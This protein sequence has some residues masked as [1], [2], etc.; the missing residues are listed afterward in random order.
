[1]TVYESLALGIPVISSDIYSIREV[2]ANRLGIYIYNKESSVETCIRDHLD[3]ILSLDR[4]A[5]INNFDS[6]E[7]VNNSRFLTDLWKV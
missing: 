5:L 7:R 4:R 3:E 2:F 1:M 6:F